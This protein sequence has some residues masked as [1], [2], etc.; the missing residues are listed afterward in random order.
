VHRPSL[1]IAVQAITPVLAS[2]LHLNR[3]T[4]VLI[5]DVSPGGPAEAVGLRVND[6]IL[7]ISGRLIDA[8]PAMLGVAFEHPPGD[9]MK[10]KVLRG[11]Q[12]IVVE[13]TSIEQ[14]H[15]IDRLIDLANPATDS[16]PELGVIGISTSKQVEEILGPLRLPLGVAVAGLIPTRSGTSHGLQTSDVIHTVN[17]DLVNSLANLRSSLEHI[18]P[19]DAV[20]LLIERAGQ[21]QYVAFNFE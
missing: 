2:A 10:I 18:K 3:T 19:G 5:T 7:D 11:D 15:G 14:P 20:A 17:G 4:G 21:M 16:F 9:R 12:E 8:V 6:I 1:G 13:T